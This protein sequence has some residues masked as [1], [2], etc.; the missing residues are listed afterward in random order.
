MPANIPADTLSANQTISHSDGSQQ[1][2]SIER[3]QNLLPQLFNP[4]QLEGEPFLRVQ[5]TDEITAGFSLELVEEVQ[6]ID[7]SRITPMPNMPH[8]V[9]GL[10]QLKGYVFWL[11]DLAQ[12]LGFPPLKNRGDRYEMVMLQTQ[13]MPLGLET[14]ASSSSEE[15]LFLGFAVQQVRGTVRVRPEDI[16]PPNANIDPTLQPHVQGQILK[17]GEVISLLNI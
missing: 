7:L 16:S 5:L 6:C 2:S 12:L 8:E 3:L 11:V 10:I 4:I 9:L 17:N 14:I 13:R 15:N 1:S